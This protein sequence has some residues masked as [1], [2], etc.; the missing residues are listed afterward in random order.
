VTLVRV[1]EALEFV[2]HGSAPA[3]AISDH[4]RR[5]SDR[6]HAYLVAIAQRL[7]HQGLTVHTRVQLGHPAEEI[8]EAAHEFDLIAM[9][10][11]GRSGIGRWVHG[12]V[13]DK[14]LRGATVPVLLIRAGQDRA[15]LPAPVR[16][17]LVPLDGSALA[18]LALPLASDLA[19]R[20]GAEVILMESDYWAQMAMAD[21]P[22]GSSFGSET[23]LE[24]V[25]EGTRAYLAGVS[26]RLA[27]AGLTAQPEVR[28]TPAADAILTCAEE[29]RA[30]LAGALDLCGD[31]GREDVLVGRS[32]R[33]ARRRPVS[34]PAT[35]QSARPTPA[36][37][38]ACA[39]GRRRRRC[40][41]DGGSRRPGR[42]RTRAP[43]TTS[44]LPIRPCEAARRPGPALRKPVVAL[45]PLLHELAR[46]VTRPRQ[47]LGQRRR[48]GRRAVPDVCPDC[49]Q[50][51]ASHGVPPRR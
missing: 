22:Y 14:V 18:E 29:R 41:R 24:E 9:G 28:F 11:Y 16:R 43:H 36:R 46:L 19:Q 5:A 13:A 39:G 12:S 35:R 3:E 8:I 23:L 2:L 30:D 4:E 51:I 25:E 1:V 37:A 21:D 33:L 47:H 10:T 49:G 45:D 31:D 15:V 7:S 42:A 38:G 44:A 27:Q 48:I 20:A 6:A 40:I 32:A 34:S 26:Q 50:P 17:L